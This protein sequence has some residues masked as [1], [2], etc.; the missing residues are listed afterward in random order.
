MTRPKGAQ[1]IM[2]IYISYI[3]LCIININV[4]LI[5]G[6]DFAVHGRK[7]AIVIAKSK[8]DRKGKIIEACTN[9]NT[10]CIIRIIYVHVYYAL[11]FKLS[12]YIHV[13]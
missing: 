3:H 8:R 5:Q 10:L 6:N 7:Y 12:L 9:F 13:S 11:K 4:V 1:N 2:F